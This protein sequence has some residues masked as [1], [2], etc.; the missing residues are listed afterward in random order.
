MPENLSVNPAE[1]AAERTR[2]AIQQCIDD[3]KCFLVEAG[4]GAGKTYSLIYALRY[5]IE[6]QGRQLLRRNQRVACITFTNVATDE[7]RSRTDRHPA[8]QADTIHSFCW[9]LIKPFQ[10]NLRKAVE[11]LANWS[12]RLAEAG[13]LADRSVDYDLGYP[14][15]EN[16]QIL[17]HHNDVLALT[18]A[19][20]EQPKFR[21]IMADRYP[22]LLVDEYQDTDK[23]F[24]DAITTHFVRGGRGPLV[25]FFG[26]HW[27][28]IYGTGCGR[29]DEPSLRVIGKEANFRSVPIVVG[30]LNRMRPELPQA[31]K[32][33]TASGFV[34]LYHTNGWQGERLTGQHS[35]GDLPPEIAHSFLER[36]RAFLATGGW[37]FSPAKTKI[38]MLTHKVLASE[39]GYRNLADV[40]PYND[41]FIQKEDAHIAF[42]VDT[43]EPVCTAYEAGKFGEMFA[44]LGEGRPSIKS[45]AEKVRWKS[46]MDTLLELRANAT[47]GDV[48]DHLHTTMLRLPNA[49]E[50]RE[51]RAAQSE[52]DSV[53]DAAAVERLRLLRAV[54]YREVVALAQFIDGHTP[55][56][57]KH[58]VKG[59]EFENVLVVVGRGWNQYDFNQMLEL[60]GGSIPANKQAMYERN[61]N[62][63]YVACSRPKKRL[64]LLFTQKLSETAI[65]TARHWFG[66]DAI[67]SFDAV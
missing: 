33:P 29:I 39:Q 5:L 48:V 45:R 44:V 62:L 35:K 63:F 25:G 65:A 4:A 49:V 26:D 14:K 1:Q 59:A 40:F 64:A 52:P 60:A 2:L 57:T 32:D 9:S 38:L 47:I 37:D 54:R 30:V 53:D 50:R 13:G 34:G 51:R 27:Q 12:E 41:A 61:R 16:H 55:F 15:V 31:V 67:H 22:V 6:K 18:V 58:G 8:I 7:I 36:L 10:T 56:D 3:R 46:D 43:L 11:T 19:L 66:N 17:L 23:A 24:A 20:M 28:K 42:F 21:A